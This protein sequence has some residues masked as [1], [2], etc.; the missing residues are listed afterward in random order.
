M[1]RCDVRIR[2]R[3][4]AS[5]RICPSVRPS[6]HLSIRLSVHPSIRP[7]VCPSVHPSVRNAK[8][9]QKAIK[10]AL[11]PLPTRTRLIGWSITQCE[12]TPEGDLTFV[13]APAH[14][15]MTDAVV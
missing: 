10:L 9:L 11:L 12:K 6:I 14:P 5:V 3:L 15:Y 1:G 4:S 8:T 2:P 13:T 7:S